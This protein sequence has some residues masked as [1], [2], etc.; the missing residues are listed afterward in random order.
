M[1]HLT[2]VLAVLSAAIVLPAH[3]HE[4]GLPHLLHDYQVWLWIGGATI[5]LLGAAL[6]LRRL[7]R[8]DSTQR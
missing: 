7:R 3:A 5:A 2:N 6:I 4:T 8:T 1:R